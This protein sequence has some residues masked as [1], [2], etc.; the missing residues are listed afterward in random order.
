[1]GLLFVWQ[2]QGLRHLQSFLEALSPSPVSSL[3]VSSL[4]VFSPHVSSP[5]VCF[6]LV[7]SLPRLSPLV[8]APPAELPELLLQSCLEHPLAQGCSICLQ[9]AANKQGRKQ[10][11]QQL[12]QATKQHSKQ[13]N[14]IAKTHICSSL[15]SASLNYK[16][17]CFLKN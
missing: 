11:T 16:N 15:L 3:L 6:P 8:S 1:M 12:K 10:E 4:P 2:A 17:L 13:A 9:Q 7:S 14:R 5:P